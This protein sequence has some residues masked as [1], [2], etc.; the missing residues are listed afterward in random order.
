MVTVSSGLWGAAHASDAGDASES[1][2]VSAGR[3][4]VIRRA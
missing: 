2:Q 1:H 3:R 4:R